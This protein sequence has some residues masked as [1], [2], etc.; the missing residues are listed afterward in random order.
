MISDFV[1]IG[2]WINLLKRFIFIIEKD[3]SNNLNKKLY[4]FNKIKK[5]LYYLYF[6]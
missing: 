6:F 2:V 4:N 1:G 3:I 5:I